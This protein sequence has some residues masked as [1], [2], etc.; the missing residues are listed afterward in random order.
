MPREGTGCP[1]H[2]MYTTRLGTVLGVGGYRTWEPHPAQ[3]T[4]QG[5][6]ELLGRPKWFIC[7]PSSRT[8]V[9]QT[10]HSSSPLC[11]G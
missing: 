6:A 3:H 4:Q 1:H 5:D 11:C 7:P 10:A 8:G 2:L 9:G